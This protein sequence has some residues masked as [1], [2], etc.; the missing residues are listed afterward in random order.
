M[1]TRIGLYGGTF[2][3]I[4]IAH[5]FVAEKAREE[6]LLDRVIFMP[7]ANPPHKLKRIITPTE[8]RFEMVQ[9]AVADNPAFQVS[10]LE[11]DRGGK[12][13]T[14][15]TLQQLSENY[16]LTKDDLFMIVGAD[17]LLDLK[18]WRLP[19][20]IIQ[21][22][23][24]VVAGRPNYFHSNIPDFIKNIVY[25]QTPMLEISSSRLREWARAGKS[26]K[27]LVPAK[28]EEYIKQH[29][30]YADV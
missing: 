21:L 18:N 29:H 27:Y 24:L 10:R 23:T 16:H 15:D 14:V 8:H 3:P 19:E 20:K 2:D 25:L 13:F 26:I 17:S 11:I 5:L 22:C 4:H 30:L 1:S 9:L 12:S 6:M 7:S 28:V